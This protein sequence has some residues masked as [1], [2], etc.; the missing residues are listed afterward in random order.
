MTRDEIR[1]QIEDVLAGEHIVAMGSVKD[2]GIDVF[3]ER[4]ADA[5]AKLEEDFPDG[6]ISG[7]KI[8]LRDAGAA[9]RDRW[10]S[11]SAGMM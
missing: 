11:R 1:P 5:R 7:V 3:V 2:D 4:L 6:F 9:I 8:I 10:A